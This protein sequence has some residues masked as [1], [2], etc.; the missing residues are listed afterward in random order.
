MGETAADCFGMKL[1][2]L[3]CS[4]IACEGQICFSSLSSC[5]NFKGRMPMIKNYLKNLVNN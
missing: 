4:F 3:S 2:T 5:N 1:T